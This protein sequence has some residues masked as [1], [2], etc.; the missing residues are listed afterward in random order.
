M[1]L[2]IISDMVNVR[3]ILVNTAMRM[4]TAFAHRGPRKRLVVA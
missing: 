1:T 2:D 4:R 3:Y